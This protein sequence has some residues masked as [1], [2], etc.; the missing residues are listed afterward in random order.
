[1]C[2][3]A[4]VR[5]S[6]ETDKGAAKVT[7]NYSERKPSDYETPVPSPTSIEMNERRYTSAPKLPQSDYETVEDDESQTLLRSPLLREKIAEHYDMEYSG[8]DGPNNKTENST[9]GYEY[10]DESK[11][12]TPNNYEYIDE[13]DHTSLLSSE[14]VSRNMIYYV[15][16]YV[17]VTCPYLECM[18]CM[19]E[20][21]PSVKACNNIVGP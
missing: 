16:L 6:S 15:I 8:T 7:A 9:S 10:I 19:V 3:E 5:S 4:T 18:R 13:G 20:C 2:Y 11:L 17:I 1:M 12:N 21:T 14:H